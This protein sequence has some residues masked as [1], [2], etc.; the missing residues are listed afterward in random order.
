VYRGAP[1]EDCDYLLNRLCEWLND[2]AFC[3]Q[4]EGRVVYGLLRAILAHLY[5]AWIHAFGDGNGR[6]ARL[7]EFEILTSSGVPSPAAHLLSNHYNQTRPEY[8]RRLDEAS[9]SGGNIWPFVSYAVNGFTE[10]LKEQIKLIKEQ[11]LTV[12]WRDYVY[13][14]F[15]NKNSKTDERQRY[16]A[17]DLSE[18][19][20]AVP[21]AQI[22][23]LSPRVAAS[24]ATKTPKTLL[25]DLVELQ[26][27]DLV[28]KTPQGYRAKREI[29]LAFLPE[30]RLPEQV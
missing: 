14:V 18:R 20:V 1:P 3:P 15:H 23:D 5:I 21:L 6:T 12:A 27:L 8:Y 28:E 24:Y 10:G 26:K 30:C 2:P 13:N 7:I 22:R 17:L 29:M 25:R 4:N 11:Q 16:L 9:K 19:V